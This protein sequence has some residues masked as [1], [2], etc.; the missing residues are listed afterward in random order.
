M[1]NLRLRKGHQ[2]FITCL[3]GELLLVLEAYREAKEAP[4]RLDISDHHRTAAERADTRRLLRPEHL[5]HL[6]SAN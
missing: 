4:C 1:L 5:H 6:L 2:A 3:T